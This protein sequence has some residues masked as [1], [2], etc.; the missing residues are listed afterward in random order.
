MDRTV[1]QYSLSTWLSAASE[2]GRD[3][4]PRRLSGWCQQG[5]LPQSGCVLGL[6]GSKEV[7]LHPAQ[8][9]WPQPWTGVRTGCQW[10]GGPGWTPLPSAWRHGSSQSLPA[11]ERKKNKQSYLHLKGENAE[12]IWNSLSFL[13]LLAFMLLA[14]SSLSISFV[15]RLPLSL[16]LSICY[17]SLFLSMRTCSILDRFWVRLLL[18]KYSLLGYS[19]T[20]SRVK[21]TL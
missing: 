2:V 17:F 1:S 4:T 14:P 10:P 13:K 16:H 12:H 21:V 18:F 5:H 8:I 15:C 9:W 6:W 19:V 7:R 11:G 3:L 20:Y